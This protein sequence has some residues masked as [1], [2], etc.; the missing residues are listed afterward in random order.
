MHCRIIHLYYNVTSNCYNE[1]KAREKLKEELEYVRSMIDNRSSSIIFFQ[2]YLGLEVD[3]NNKEEKKELA[4]K[5][6]KLKERCEEYRH[7]YY[8]KKNHSGTRFFTYHFKF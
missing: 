4:E 8:I 6:K 1:F 7:K 3:L 2:D 5:I